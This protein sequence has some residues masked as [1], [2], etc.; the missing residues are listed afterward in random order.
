MTF[1]DLN[2]NNPMLMALAD[3]EYEHPTPIQAKAFPII[4]S[5]QNVIGIAQTGTGKT[6]AYLLPLLRQLTFSKQK[7]PR[8]LILAPTRVLVLQILNEVRKLTKYTSFR[9]VGVYGGTSL[10]SQKQT[11]YDGMDILVA[12]PGRLMDLSLTGV[13][14]LK[15]VQKLVID[16]V[17]EMLSL[18]FRSQIK[19]VL[20]L[21]PEKR[22]TLMFSATLTDDVEALI[23]DTIVNPIKVEISSHGTP[24]EQIEQN[25]YFVPNFNTKINLFEHLFNDGIDSLKI[26]VFVDSK[27]SADRVFDRINK[28]YPD[29]VGVIH[30]NKA[31]NTREATI[32]KFKDDTF[33]ILIATDIIALG[34]DFPDI[35]HVV[36]FEIPEVAGDYIHRIGRTGRADRKGISISFS[37]SNDVERIANIESIMKTSI[38]VHEVPQEIEISDIL[39]PDEEPAKLF[40]KNYLKPPKIKPPQGAF[41]EKSTKN[42]KVNHGGPKRRLE[43]FDKSGKPKKN[44]YV[45][46]KRF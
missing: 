32:T 40:D 23:N 33:R 6:F 39:L 17:D 16:E 28:M 43:K 18:G 44:T 46:K 29:Q 36:N 20:D 8:I 25:L 37:T 13:L 38:P 1:E 31:Q 5:G 45:K 22:Q 2:L 14:R 30:S 26:L 35:T 11:V 10:S 15:S 3:I 12:T 42:Q 4:M 41:H 19:R 27:K 7:D 24:L 34:M 21:L 9:S